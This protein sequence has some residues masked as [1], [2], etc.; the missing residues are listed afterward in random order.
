MVGGIALVPTDD[1]DQKN[2]LLDV[3]LDGLRHRA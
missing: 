2:R 1:A 3:A